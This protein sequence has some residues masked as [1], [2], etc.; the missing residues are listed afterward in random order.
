M[1]VHLV[2]M[3]KAVLFCALTV[4]LYVLDVSVIFCVQE[5]LHCFSISFYMCLSLFVYM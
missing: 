5:I 2:F 4:G 1:L 3:F